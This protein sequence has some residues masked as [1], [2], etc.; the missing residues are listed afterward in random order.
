[1]AKGV[2]YSYMKMKPEIQEKLEHNSIIFSLFVSTIDKLA[3]LLFYTRYISLSDNSL[4]SWSC[5]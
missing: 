1:M 4:D 3:M 5:H 2:N